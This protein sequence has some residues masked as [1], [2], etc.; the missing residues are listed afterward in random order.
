MSDVFV[1]VHYEANFCCST[2]SVVRG[3]IERNSSSYRLSIFFQLSRYDNY[4]ERPP[5]QSFRSPG[6]ISAVFSAML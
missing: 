1:A 3:N 6:V 2:R 5:S 4:V